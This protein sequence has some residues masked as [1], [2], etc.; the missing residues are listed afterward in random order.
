MTGP[1]T[2]AGEL[3]RL[4][5]AACATDSKPSTRMCGGVRD[6]VAAPERSEVQAT[7]GP[8]VRSASDGWDANQ[9]TE[10]WK[11]RSL[12]ACAGGHEHEA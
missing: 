4:C 5:P 2:G 10:A 11:G 6:R 1:A 12:R 8:G 3:R 9:W 7:A